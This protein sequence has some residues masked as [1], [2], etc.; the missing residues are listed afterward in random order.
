MPVGGGPL[1][2]HSLNL[3][4]DWDLEAGWT[5]PLKVPPAATARCQPG[6]TAFLNSATTQGGSRS[7]S[8]QVCRS[9][10]HPT[11]DAIYRVSRRPAK[12]WSTGTQHTVVT[13]F[14]Y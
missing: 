12:L 3:K 11:H 9:F 8:T 10:L 13:L 4:T 6:S 14:S 2:Y 1:S 5:R 7:S